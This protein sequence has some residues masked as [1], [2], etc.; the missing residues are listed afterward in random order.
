MKTK[1]Y[2]IRIVLPALLLLMFNATLRAQTTPN[3]DSRRMQTLRNLFRP[4]TGSSTG[5]YGGGPVNIKSIPG[6]EQ[7][8]VA[9]MNQHGIQYGQGKVDKRI[10]KS[11]KPRE[12]LAGQNLEI[13]TEEIFAGENLL[14]W[15]DSIATANPPADKSAGTGSN[16]VIKI[17][18]GI[19]TVPFFEMNP[20]I[21]Q[22]VVMQRLGRITAFI[23]VSKVP[24]MSTK[25]KNG[26]PLKGEEEPIGA[27]DLGELHP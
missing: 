10:A 27:Y 26:K 14:N 23:V 2:M 1:I 20:Q 15:L 9:E 24:L 22:D 21:A 17:V 19:Y 3:D 8:Y 16:L 7:E 4:K 12:R 5:D 13:T 25:G 6:C 11:T 18:F